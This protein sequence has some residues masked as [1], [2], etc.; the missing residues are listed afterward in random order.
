MSRAAQGSILARPIDPLA[1]AS[2]LSISFEY[3]GRGKSVYKW[4]PYYP[5]QKTDCFTS[6]IGVRLKGEHG[7]VRCSHSAGHY[8]LCWGGGGVLGITVLRLGDSS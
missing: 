4:S 6:S 8:I 2:I 3:E 5:P 1:Q 7:G